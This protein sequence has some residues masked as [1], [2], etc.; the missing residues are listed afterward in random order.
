MEYTHVILNWTTLSETNNT[1]FEVQQR[2]DS[3][4]FQKIGFREGQGT[5]TEV[6]DYRFRVSDLEPGSYTFRLRQVDLDGTESFSK[7]VEVRVSLDEAYTW[8]KAAPNPVMDQ[9]TI[10]VQVRETQDVAVML[11]DLLGRRVTT[12]HR[13]AM[14]SDTAHQINIDATDL[15]SGVYLL[16]VQGDTFSDTQRLT[17]VR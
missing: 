5:T 7:P 14:T 16:R 6:T 15:V 8:T 10:S 1:G 12:L 2:D 4:T 13:G 9:S 11:Y 3:G 17:I